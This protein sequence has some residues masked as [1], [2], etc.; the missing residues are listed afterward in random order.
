MK[1]NRLIAAAIGLTCLF[2]SV[3]FATS[4]A[5]DGEDCG[6]T[7]CNGTKTLRGCYACCNTHCTD[8]TGCQDWCDTRSFPLQPAPEPS[9]P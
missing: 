2:S 4:T 6:K 5:G 8:A 1:S 3:T 9:N 7:N